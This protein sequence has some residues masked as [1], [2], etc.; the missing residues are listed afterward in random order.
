MAKQYFIQFDYQGKGWIDIHQVDSLR[1][2]FRKFEGITEAGNH[3][4]VSR[5]VQEEVVY[6]AYLNAEENSEDREL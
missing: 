6:Q 1:D 2:V 3:R 5:E 4:I